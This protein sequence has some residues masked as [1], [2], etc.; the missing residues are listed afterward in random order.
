M[1]KFLI[2]A[3]LLSATAIAA[4][5]AAQ[6]WGNG[7]GNNNSRSNIQ[8]QVNQIEQRI[9]RAAQRRTISGSEANRLLRRADQL[10][11]LAYRYE[12]NGLTQREHYELQSRLQNLR[13]QLQEDRRDGRNYGRRW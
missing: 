6:S 8:R 5:A 9:Q 10:E 4:P 3:A 11:R 2:S 12:R 13:A 1:R 7:Y